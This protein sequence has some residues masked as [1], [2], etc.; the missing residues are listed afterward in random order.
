MPWESGQR[1][2][3]RACWFSTHY[4]FTFNELITFLAYVSDE[5]IEA[6]H[7]T[8]ELPRPTY[9]QRRAISSYSQFQ[10]NSIFLYGDDGFTMRDYYYDKSA[11][12]AT[13][14]SA[15]KAEH[16]LFISHIFVLGLFRAWFL[17]TARA[18][19]R[20]LQCRYE[21]ISIISFRMKC[22][23]T[24]QEYSMMSAI[25]Y[26]AL[27]WWCRKTWP[28]S[29]HAMRDVIYIDAISPAP[30]PICAEKA[31]WQGHYRAQLAI[32]LAI[33]HMAIMEWLKASAHAGDLCRYS[34][35]V[36]HACAYRERF[37]IARRHHWRL[38][39]S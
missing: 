34:P 6:S 14:A 11:A 24:Q 5:P 39:T 16:F 1:G 28:R 30:V 8:R 33:A 36:G 15:K 23:F 10:I 7:L 26:D 2:A 37:I 32:G 20:P 21:R 31:T 13:G 9:A 3:E 29:V 35:A 38:A 19:G 4:F 22:L 27:R 12:C 18:T 25:Y 17:P